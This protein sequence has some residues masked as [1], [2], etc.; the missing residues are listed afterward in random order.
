MTRALL[1]GLICLALSA[2]VGA[3]AQAG[4]DESA[5]DHVRLTGDAYELTLSKANGA[6]LSITDRAAGAA[7][8]LGSRNGCLWGS[9]YQ[10][11]P[12]AYRGGCSFS[13]GGANAFSYAWDAAGSTLILKY[14]SDPRAAQQADATA[15]IALGADGFDLKLAVTN[16]MGAMMTSVLFPSDL[17]LADDSIEAAYLPY[18]LPGVRLKPGFFR[19]HRSISAVYPSARAF[20]DYLAVDANGGRLAYYSVN[21]AGKIRPAVI[22]FQDD[23]KIRAGTFYAFHTFQAWTPDG[24]TFETPVVRVR[25][26]QSPEETLAAYRAENHIADYPDLSG[27]LGDLAAQVAR[28]PLIKLDLRQV[29]RPFA[30]LGARL[31][32]VR[33]PAILHPVSYWPRGFDQNYPDFLPPDARFGGVADFQAF[34]DAAHARGLFVMPYTNPTWWDDQSPT[35]KSAPDISTLAVLKPDGQPVYES[36]GPNRG[37]VASPHAA[38]VAE[39]LARLMAQWRDEATVDFVLQDQIGSRSWLRD[40][41]PAAPD[42]MQYSDAWLEHTRLYAIQRLMTEDGWDRLAA[43]EVGFSG[44]LLTGATR[45]NPNGVRWGE[46]SRGNTAFGEGNWEP[47]PLGVWLFH[48]KVLFYHHDLDTLPMNGGVEVL[49]WN[50]AF[51]VMAGYHW[52]ELRWADANWIAAA[53][54]FQAAV[55]ARTA[56]RTLDAYRSL[57]PEVTESRFGDLAVIANWNPGK[58]F[59]I[60]GHTITPAGC[61]ARTDDGSLVAGVLEQ[62]FNGSALT[63]GPHYL[64]V[65][66]AGA[67]L[68]VRQPV[69]ADTPLTIT[70]PEDWDAATGV[71]VRAFDRGNQLLDPVAASLDGQRVTFSCARSADRYEIS[72]VAP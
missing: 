68:V 33:A 51:G 49:T 24:G 15:T 13:A 67:V 71:V 25:V 34:I 63:A 6:I 26:G 38:G 12:S 66:R 40:F 32:L 41:H 11:T 44:S 5:S 39:R 36:Y 4:F 72:V 9:S 64:I 45:W 54:A 1:P 50:A 35:A 23:D 37:F 70:L 65:E 58:S 19:A 69:G 30:E 60:D 52:P 42:P 59:D 47:Y 57:S 55:L 8:T 16:R 22:G 29:N 2:R 46:G 43:T 17:L 31:D 21:P 20:A 7:L 56:G 27:K 53:S 3:R 48:D 14:V 10:T 62:R 18:Y 28:S 61:L